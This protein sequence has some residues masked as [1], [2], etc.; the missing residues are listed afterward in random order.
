MK[1]RGVAALM[2]LYITTICLVLLPMLYVLALSFLT[3]GERFGVAVQLGSSAVAHISMPK[4][5]FNRQRGFGARLPQDS[6]VA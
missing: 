1:K 3:R 6:A 4:I 5:A 2:P